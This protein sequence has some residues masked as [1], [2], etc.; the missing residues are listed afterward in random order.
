MRASLEFD[1]H[2]FRLVEILVCAKDLLLKV[3]KNL[4]SQKITTDLLLPEVDSKKALPVAPAALSPEVTSK[5]ARVPTK[6]IK[7]AVKAVSQNH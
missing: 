2:S 4:K 1:R 7:K 3:K 6:V 5:A